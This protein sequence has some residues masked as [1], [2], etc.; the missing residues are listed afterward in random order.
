MFLGI[1]VTAQ[2][3][4]RKKNRL[5]RT[6]QLRPFCC[7]KESLGT[8]ILPWPAGRYFYKK[9]FLLLLLHYYR[10][11]DDYCYCYYVIRNPLSG[12]NNSMAMHATTATV[13]AT[14]SLI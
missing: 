3:G 12:G 10:Y 1:S 11:F 8:I 9:L 13:T 4:T 5:N 7:R 6:K 2:Q 14:T